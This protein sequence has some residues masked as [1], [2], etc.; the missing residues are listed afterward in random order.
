MTGLTRGSRNY[1]KQKVTIP[2]RAGTTVGRFVGLTKTPKVIEKNLRR[3][4]RRREGG[5]VR[6]CHEERWN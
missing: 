3:D 6:S 4:S 5:E 1:T 2:R